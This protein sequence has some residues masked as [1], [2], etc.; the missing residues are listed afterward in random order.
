MWGHGIFFSISVIGLLAT[1]WNVTFAP[2][3]FCIGFI[4]MLVSMI[5]MVLA[6][7]I[8]PK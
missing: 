5:L 1:I 6:F 7:C 2:I 8:E 3:M 4:G